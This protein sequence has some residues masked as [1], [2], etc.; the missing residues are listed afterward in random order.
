[1]IRFSLSPARGA[2]LCSILLALF[3]LQTPV[4]A[5]A[6]NPYDETIA[7]EGDPG[8]G[9]LDQTDLDDLPAGEENPKVT[10]QVAWQD[11]SL[12]LLPLPRILYL[13]P[14]GSL[15]V[16]LPDSW[17]ILEARSDIGTPSAI[18]GW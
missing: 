13:G 3:L 2:L 11:R 6:R 14:T 1:M 17:S 16:F 5:L 10:G 7:T 8:D 18:R 4:A 9:V 15:W 12:R